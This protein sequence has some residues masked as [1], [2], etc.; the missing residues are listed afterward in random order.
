MTVK[1]DSK[2]G[3]ITAILTGYAYETTPNKKSI[4]GQ[5]HGGDEATLGR[6]AQG[7]SGVSK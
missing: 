3:A 5:T 4:A 7:A 6:L 1:I 2:T